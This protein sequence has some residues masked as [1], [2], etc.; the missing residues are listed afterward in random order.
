VA[1]I[2]ESAIPRFVVR[3]MSAAIRD[4]WLVSSIIFVRD[5]WA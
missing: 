5:I 4:K 2:I 3:P 1:T